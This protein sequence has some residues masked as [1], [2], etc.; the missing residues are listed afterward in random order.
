MIKEQTAIGQQIRMLRERCRLSIRQLAEQAGVTAAMISLIERDKTSPSIVT[1]QKILAALGSDMATF[2]SDEEQHQEMPVFLRERMRVI[3][4]AVRS[5]TMV[6][7]K[8]QDVA[9]ELLDEQIQPCCENPPYE[10]LKCDVGGYVLAGELVLDVKG[11]SPRILRP[12]DAFYVTRGQP[13]RGYA[14][15]VTT[16]LLTVCTPVRY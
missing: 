4:D 14:H 16:R 13:H 2:F 15:K 5:Y 7:P 6:F 12:G 11:Q 3:S 1:L 10:T 8:H 9:V